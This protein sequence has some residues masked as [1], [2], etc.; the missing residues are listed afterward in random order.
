MKIDCFFAIVNHETRGRHAGCR[1][2]S[3]GIQV[4][5]FSWSFTTDKLAN[6]VYITI[7]ACHTFC[8]DF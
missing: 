7:I 8:D 3:I 4:A 1:V 6:V 5:R 2:T